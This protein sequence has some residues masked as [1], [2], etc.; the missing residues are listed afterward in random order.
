MD[1]YA[2]L[3]WTVIGCFVY[4]LSVY[5]MFGLLLVVSAAENVRLARQDRN[6]D[7]ETLAESRFTIPVSLIAPA[8][9]EEVVIAAAVR[10]LL[11]LDYPEYEVIVVNDGSRDGT[12]EELKRTFGLQRREMF[13]RRVFRTRSV[14][15]VYQSASFPR[16]LVIDKENGGKADALNC[17]FNFARYRY[18]CTVD[19]DTVFFPNALLKGMRLALKDPARVLGVTSQVAISR[20]PEETDP[21]RPGSQRIDDKALTNF[22]MLDYLRAFLNNRV[23]WSRLDF[24]LCSVGAFAIWRRDVVAELGGFSGDFTCEDIEFTFR[25]HEHFRRIKQP[26]RI[27]SMGDMVGRSEGPDTISR[28]ISQRARWQ[29]VITETVW[30][31]RRMLLNPRYGTVG[32]L[33]MPYYVLAEVVAPIVQVVAVLTVPL[34]WWLGVFSLP[35]FLLFL[36]TVALANGVLTNI[37]IL[38]HDSGSRIY[39]IGDLFR[40]ML[41][42]PLDLFIYR[43]IL[44]YAQAKGFVDFLRGDKSWHKFKR[45]RREASR[46]AA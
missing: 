15:G 1:L 6:E 5:T 42:G 17:G 44:F 35:Q 12:L 4:L 43:P 23:G 36:A 11:A 37:A 40:L 14:R 9:N 10:S 8:F 25:A 18:V 34:A 20:R 21:A 16:L 24:M 33:G 28:L 38:L 46:A 41:L 32:L 30:H 26:Y 19:G 2:I 3:Y 27:V 29:R 22:Q 31:Y 39:P 7:Y 45:N 13:Y